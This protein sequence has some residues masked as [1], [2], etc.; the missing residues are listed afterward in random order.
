MQVIRILTYPTRTIH[1]NP[2]PSVVLWPAGSGLPQRRLG[3]TSPPAG[4]APCYRSNYSDVTRIWQPA[5]SHRVACQQH[6]A[7][8]CRWWPDTNAR[9]TLTTQSER[10]G[11][12]LQREQAKTCPAN[13]PTSYH[14]HPWH[15]REGVAKWGLC[16][17]L[18]LRRDAPICNEGVVLSQPTATRSGE[19]ACTWSTEEFKLRTVHSVVL[20]V[21]QVA[22]FQ[23]WA[24]VLSYPWLGHHFQKLFK[25]AIKILRANSINQLLEKGFSI[26]WAGW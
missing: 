22:R 9:A 17:A 5:A 6:F 23:F 25:K 12:R 13:R 3:A 4:G 1:R 18:R 2:T 24:W 11:R 7:L 19:R 26:P 20:V 15:Q 8:L 16:R 21:G 10:E 14:H